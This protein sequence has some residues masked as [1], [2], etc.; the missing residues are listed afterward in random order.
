MA[1]HRLKKLRIFSVGIVDSPA[2]EREYLVYK[3][4]GKED[5][6]EGGETTVKR[7]PRADEEL[8]QESE[9]E[10]QEKKTK[11]TVD[12]NAK[13]KVEVSAD[14]PKV[15]EEKATQEP[16]LEIPEGLTEEEK[17]AYTDFMKRCLK[18]GK[19]MKECAMEWQKEKEAEKQ[20][21]YPEPGTNYPN[22]PAGSFKKIFEML[23]T[24]IQ[25]EKDEDKK[26]ALQTLKAALSKIVGGTYPYPE[27]K[28]KPEQ[29]SEKEEKS[30]LAAEMKEKLAQLEKE[31]VEKKYEAELEELRQEIREVASSVKKVA[32]VVSK[33]VPL[34]KAVVKEEEKP[35]QSKVEELLKS[36]EFKDAT[37][38]EQ[39]RLLIRTLDEN[40]K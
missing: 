22:I 26:K 19:S 38:G 35:R 27:A 3:R 7:V 10:P 6:K 40:F 30:N 37:P 25:A 4:L 16:E 34:R 20:D 13:V 1:R 9:G 32:E 8:I 5:L 33:N 15:A 28:Q 29:T 21:P 11:V 12:P 14:E 17:S 2:N 23:D 39:L 24:L 31:L 18:S 36:K